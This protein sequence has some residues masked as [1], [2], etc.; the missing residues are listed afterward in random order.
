MSSRVEVNEDGISEN[1]QTLLSE[2]GVA[3]LWEDN[4]LEDKL[5]P[6]PLTCL[7]LLRFCN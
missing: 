6:L 7:L 2:E 1:P 3:T 5:E 4:V